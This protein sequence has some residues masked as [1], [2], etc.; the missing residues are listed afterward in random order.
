LLRLQGQEHAKSERVSEKPKTKRVSLQ[1]DCPDMQREQKKFPPQQPE[2]GEERN[3][4]EQ[5]EE[6]LRTRTAL[7]KFAGTGR[8]GSKL[9][10]AQRRW[11]P[12]SRRGDLVADKRAQNGKKVPIKRRRMEATH[13]KK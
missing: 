9:F 4:D 3:E 13:E 8:G 1:K 7:T 10:F 2:L 11:T 6:R 5:R 12:E